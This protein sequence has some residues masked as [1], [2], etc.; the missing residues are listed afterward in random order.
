VTSGVVPPRK[1]ML[2]ALCLT[3]LTDIMK[4]CA[5]AVRFTWLAPH[6]PTPLVAAVWRCL[7]R[8]PARGAGFLLPCA[9]EMGPP[10]HGI[11]EHA[12]WAAMV[13]L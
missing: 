11:V 6:P 12:S 4:A 8:V 2:C 13:H 5:L 3:A 7:W 9:F 1:D 10:G